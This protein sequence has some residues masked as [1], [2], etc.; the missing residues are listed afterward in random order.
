MSPKDVA[1]AVTDPVHHPAPAVRVG[2]MTNLWTKY[3]IKFVSLF[4]GIELPDS[5]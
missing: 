4:V 2:Y 1:E 3:H 5:L